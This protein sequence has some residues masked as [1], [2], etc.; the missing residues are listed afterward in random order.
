MSSSVNIKLWILPEKMRPKTNSG[1]QKQK[2]KNKAKKPQR[3]NNEAKQ[4]PQKR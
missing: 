2:R 4:R 1:K 3:E